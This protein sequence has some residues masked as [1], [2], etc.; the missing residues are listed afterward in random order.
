MQTQENALVSYEKF[1]LP[2]VSGDEFAGDDLSDDL[3]GVELSFP[4]IRIPSGGAL[5]F[6]L[7]GGNPE[8][9]DYA[10]T[11]EG[12]ILFS[13]PANAYWQDSNYE[14]N[15]EERGAPICSSVDGITGV[16]VPGGACAACPM[17]AWKSAEKGNGKACKNMR[18]LYLLRDGDYMPILMALSPTSLRP[19]S[20]FVSAVF[21]ARR[22][23]TCGSVVQIGL[24]RANNGKDDYSVAT[25]KKLFDFSGEKLAQARQY[26]DGFKEQIKL[27][28]ARKAAEAEVAGNDAEIY[29]YGGVLERGGGTFTVET[30]DGGRD[31]IPA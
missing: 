26:A 31:A 17:N 30:I 11:I 6:E 3:A 18:H 21:A 1:A 28:L 19:Y 5:Q 10:K 2:E 16:G 25:F 20:D 7:P 14:E 12:V 23:G 29:D 27:M 8:D 15:E 22:R 9:P 24:K 13:H 4:R